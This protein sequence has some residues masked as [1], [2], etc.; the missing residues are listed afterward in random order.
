LTAKYA[1]DAKE[2]L[3]GC[4]ASSMFLVFLGGLCV[5]GGEK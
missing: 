1:K 5:L 3:D 2:N 4:A